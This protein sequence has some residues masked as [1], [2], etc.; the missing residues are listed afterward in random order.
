MSTEEEYDTNDMKIK[1]INL[2]L[3]LLGFVLNV[4]IVYVLYDETLVK[5]TGIFKK[6]D[7]FSILKLVIIVYCLIHVPVVRL[8]YDPSK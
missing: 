5:M 4:L 2:G 8:K 7:F 1:S 6:A 3:W